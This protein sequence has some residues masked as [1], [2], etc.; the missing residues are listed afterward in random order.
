MAQSGARLVEVG[1]TNRTYARDYERAVTAQTAALLKVHPSNF[2]VTGFTASATV[3]DLAP[4][5][6]T[7]GVVLVEDVG[8]GAVLDTARFGLGHEPTIGESVAAGSDV[9]TASGDKL[10]GGPQAGLIAGRRGV[11]DRIAA[12][13]L[14]RA[15]RADKS[16]MAGMAETLRHY[17]R[18]EAEWEVPVWRM[19]AAPL[20]ELRERADRMTARLREGGMEA[21]VSPSEA[22]VGGGSLPGKSMASVAVVLGGI[23]APDEYARLLRV[24][25]PGVYGRIEAGRVWLDLRSVLPEDDDVMVGAVVAAGRGGE[26]EEA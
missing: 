8:S 3:A 21:H 16:C 5:A 25:Q 12:H 20:E 4:V 22:T 15:V 19:I 7:A 14:A 10:L 6:R 23:G 2:A 17:L 26:R 11:V 18:G 24:G 9:V 13:P 1:T